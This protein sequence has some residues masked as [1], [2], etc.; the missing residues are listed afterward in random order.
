MLHHF[1]RRR[2]G[3]GDPYI[4]ADTKWYRG[5]LVFPLTGLLWPKTIS[6]STAECFHCVSSAE[7]GT[8]VGF[9]YSAQA[10]AG[11]LTHAHA[12]TLDI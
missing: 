7:L 10:E 6:R 2:G 8:G 5:G 12:L 3:G 4:S 9:C 11:S 1:G